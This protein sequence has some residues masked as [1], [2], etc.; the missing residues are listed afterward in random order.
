[1]NIFSN[2]NIKT[3]CDR[4]LWIWVVLILCCLACSDDDEVTT[5]N[6]VDKTSYNIPMDDLHIRDPFIVVDRNEKCYYLIA[7]KTSGKKTD[8]LYAYKSLDLKRWK[9]VGYVYRRSSDFIEVDYFWAPD[10]YEYKGNYYCFVTAGGDHV[11]R[12]TTILKGGA[13]PIDMY[14]PLLKKEKPY[15]TPLDWNSIDGSLFVDNQGTPW[16]IFSREWV[17]VKDGEMWTVKMKEDLT[18]AIGE[19]IKLFSASESGWA[20]TGESVYTTDAPFIYKDELSGNLIMLWSSHIGTEQDKTYCI[21]QAISKSGKVEGPWEHELLPIYSSD[22]GHAMIFEDLYGRLK[23]AYHSPN[24]G[25]VN[26]EIKDLTL[27]DGKFERFDPSKYDPTTPISTKDFEVVYHTLPPQDNEQSFAKLFD[28]DIYSYWESM[29]WEAVNNTHC[30]DV[31]NGG[32]IHTVDDYIFSS[33]NGINPIKPPYDF[34]IDMK[35]IY[36]VKSVDLMAVNHRTWDNT[37]YGWLQRIKDYEYWIADGELSQSPTL[38]DFN[39]LEWK[40]IGEDICP[41]RTREYRTVET[42]EQF[43]GRYLKL[44]IKSLYFLGTTVTKQEQNPTNPHLG[45]VIVGEIRAKGYR[46]K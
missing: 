36:N 18:E 26:V 40:K 8:N 4:S 19:P 22:G 25:I 14:Q 17:D 34:I 33:K 43:V 45:H 31:W 41:V 5:F 2:L 6:M 28:G 42:S 38:D 10:F 35:N 30:G 46:I 39:S 44:R 20:G 27:K 32:H 3:L 37:P 15:I 24:T 13:S 1:M 29:E 11:K 23:I 21:G 16:M 9:D 7:P 12:G